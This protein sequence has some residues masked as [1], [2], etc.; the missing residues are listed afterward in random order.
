MYNQ[1]FNYNNYGQQNNTGGMPGQGQFNNQ[2]TGGYNNGMQN[3]GGSK[4]FRND[5]GGQTQWKAKPKNM[6]QPNLSN[7]T[8]F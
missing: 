2:N 4:G 7:G 1:G 6:Y 3:R 8:G 5:Q